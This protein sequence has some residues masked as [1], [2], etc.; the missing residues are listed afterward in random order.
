MKSVVVEASTVAKAIESAWL[1]AGKPEEYFIRVL[2]EHT[3]GF[4]GFGAVKAKKKT[5]GKLSFSVVEPMYNR[6][7][8][9][10]ISKKNLVGN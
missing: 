9:I 10:T 1:K 2:Q 6:N 5:N 3:S 4:L 7:P 8:D